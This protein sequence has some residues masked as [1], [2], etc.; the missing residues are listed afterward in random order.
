MRSSVRLGRDA[1][2]ATVGGLVGETATRPRAPP[3]CQRDDDISFD[4]ISRRN[5]E[6]ARA[7]WVRARRWIS[8]HRS[9]RPRVRLRSFRVDYSVCFVSM[10]ARHRRCR[11]GWTRRGCSGGE[12]ARAF[13]G[14][15]QPRS[16][17]PSLETP[18][19]STRTKPLYFIARFWIIVTDVSFSHSYR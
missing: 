19:S 18:V 7:T 11:C 14:R 5:V 17:R 15:T 6:S 16:S 3:P 4:L 1:S 10:A 2:R 12:T 9:R 13:V 8:D